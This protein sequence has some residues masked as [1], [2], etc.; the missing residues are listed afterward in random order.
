MQ[1]KKPNV[2]HYIKCSMIMTGIT[3]LCFTVR[4]RVTL[5]NIGVLDLGVG[6]GKRKL[7]GNPPSNV[8]YDAL[9]PRKLPAR[10]YQL[11]IFIIS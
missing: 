4:K 8:I 3:T 7:I 11:T 10:T 1:K 5:K 9:L 6:E 2:V